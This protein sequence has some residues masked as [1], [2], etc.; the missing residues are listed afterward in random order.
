[1]NS[2]MSTSR[3]EVSSLQIYLQL[4]YAS[5]KLLGGTQVKIGRGLDSFH[6]DENKFELAT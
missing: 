6:R 3:R 2:Q 1:M 5:N 4:S